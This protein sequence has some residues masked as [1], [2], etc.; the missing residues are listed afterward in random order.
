[1][2]SFVSLPLYDFQVLLFLIMVLLTS[3]SKSNTLFVLHRLVIIE[4]LPYN[5]A[6]DGNLC[7]SAPLHRLH[8][9]GAGITNVAEAAKSFKAVFSRLYKIF[10]WLGMRSAPVWP[11]RWWEWTSSPPGQN[12]WWQKDFIML[13]TPFMKREEFLSWRARGKEESGASVV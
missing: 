13:P 2:R 5:S 7:C 3:W 9:N 4:T 10:P 1:M 8:P 12:F 6:S 11:F